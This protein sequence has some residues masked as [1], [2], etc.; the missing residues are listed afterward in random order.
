MSLDLSSAIAQLQTL[1][2]SMQETFGGGAG[3]QRTI[4]I[5]AN[6]EN[7]KSKIQALNKL[8][9]QLNVKA[10]TANLVT[11][12]KKAVNSTV[13]NPKWAT[14]VRGSQNEIRQAVSSVIEGST[15]K[16][17]QQQMYGALGMKT[18]ASPINAYQRPS[19]PY[20]SNI[21]GRSYDF[22]NQSYMQAK[23]M[24]KLRS[25]I[26]GISENAG[27]VRL[28][29]MRNTIGLGG[30]S[31]Q[32]WQQW[33]Q[34]MNRVPYSAQLQKQ[35]QKTSY[36]DRVMYNQY[37]NA[38][39][40]IPYT[41]GQ[42]V[43]RYDPQTSKLT[44]QGMLASTATAGKSDTGFGN[45]H[46]SAV[47]LFMLSQTMRS[48]AY[49][50]EAGFD[51]IA[52]AYDSSALSFRKTG[53][54]SGMQGEEFEKYKKDVRSL[55]GETMTPLST[56]SEMGYAFA[57]RGYMDPSQIKQTLAPLATAGLITGRNPVDMGKS[58]MSLMQAWNP[59]S[60][61]SLKEQ[62][63]GL[64]GEYS[65]LM[66]YAYGHSPLET[67]WFKD[68]ANYAAPVFAGL[69]FKP[70]ETMSTFM[71]MSQMIPTAGIGAR[72][73]RM[74]IS[75]LFN[76]DKL[77]QVFDKYG[78]DLESKLRKIKESGGGLAEVF[79]MV[80]SQVKSLPEFQ[81]NTFLRTIGGGVRGGMALQALLPVIS[82]ISEY[83][84]D[85]KAESSGYTYQ[86]RLEY[87]ATP[88]GQLKSAEA[89]RE[90]ILFG[91][92]EK[93]VG[94]RTAFMNLENS[95]LKLAEKMPSQAL[96][97][98]YGAAKGAGW[99]ANLSE[100]MANIGI[101]S[102]LGNQPGGGLAGGLGKAAIGGSAVMTAVSM[103]S[104][105]VSEGLRKGQ[106]ETKRDVSEAIKDLNQ[107]EA[108]LR[109]AELMS[110][111]TFKENTG[112]EMGNIGDNPMERFWHSL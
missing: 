59:Q 36:Q 35:Y 27:A 85:I 111:K 55:A 39:A 82:N 65:D 67:R 61:T 88:Y 96:A 14:N 91:M 24:E 110:F 81:Q 63:P 15:T 89:E 17:Y 45:E 56:L 92:G 87:A 31:P 13:F 101:L 112:I 100:F 104:A 95:M 7:A 70:T 16:K 21:G 11:D 57:T 102:F 90:S 40:K 5:S 68:I 41:P 32:M 79:E 54:V 97:A 49:T 105:V 19:Q 50:L 43:K 108:G 80:A 6:V 84:R 22:Y 33:N 106:G 29:K 23:A 103:L 71:A 48:M 60:L 58:V 1:Q 83:E 52:Q 107:P 98:G 9:V 51:R 76:V 69:G 2:K 64:I 8:P 26:Q 93:T 46:M 94:I 42:P 53:L 75:N 20:K 30:Y 34:S 66:T 25:A 77:T 18:G 47:N 44:T 3:G 74:A 28:N 10:N 109:L 62:A 4:K 99:S 37:Q 12:M 86:K 72:S 73:G 78:V 38:R